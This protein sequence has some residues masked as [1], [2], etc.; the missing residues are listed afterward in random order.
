MLFRG[1]TNDGKLPQLSS[2]EG[3]VELEGFDKGQRVTGLTHVAIHQAPNNPHYRVDGDYRNCGVGRPR[4]RPAVRQCQQAQSLWFGRW[5]GRAPDNGQYGISTYN[6]NFDSMISLVGKFL[7]QVF[8]STNKNASA[9]K[10]S[11]AAT[12]VW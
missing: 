10:F 8:E 9:P 6:P 11:V 1:Y 12:Q 4:P 7:D 5:N 2:Q 3:L